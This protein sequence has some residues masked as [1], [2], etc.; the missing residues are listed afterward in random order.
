MAMIDGSIDDI[1]FRL[2]DAWLR[3]EI[4]KKNL[5]VAVSDED[6]AQIK[7]RIAQ[8][9]ECCDE[10]IKRVVNPL[11][12]LFSKVNETSPQDMRDVVAEL[13]SGLVRF[14][15]EIMEIKKIEHADEDT[16]ELL[17]KQLEFTGTLLQEVSIYRLLKFQERLTPLIKGFKFS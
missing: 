9:S 2:R 4:C 12:T 8:M 7:F 14:R 1:E 17:E 11:I 5:V 3:I 6:F 16:V 15:K 13:L 10:T